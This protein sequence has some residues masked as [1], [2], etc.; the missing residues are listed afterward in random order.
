MVAMS[1]KLKLL[2]LCCTLRGRGGLHIV[3]HTVQDV[4]RWMMAMANEQ[5]Q[6]SGNESQC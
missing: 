3:S 2:G 5:V 4:S 6:S 1:Y